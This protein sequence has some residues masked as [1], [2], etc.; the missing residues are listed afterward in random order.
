MK[1]LRFMGFL[2]DVSRDPMGNPIGNPTKHRSSLDCGLA[3]ASV[4][5]SE[6]SMVAMTTADPVAG[7]S[8]GSGGGG[9]STQKNGEFLHENFSGTLMSG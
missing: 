1:M 8:G 4:G 2:W 5:L 7:G 6:T 9:D 3:E